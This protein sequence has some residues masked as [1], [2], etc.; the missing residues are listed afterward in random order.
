MSK[1][2]GKIAEWFSVK[3]G[4][5]GTC[6]NQ[7]F[8]RKNA[9]FWKKVI[10]VSTRYETQQHVTTQKEITFVSR[11]FP[12]QKP[13]KDKQVSALF[14]YEACPSRKL[15][16]IRLTYL[17]PNSATVQLPA[18]QPIAAIGVSQVTCL[19]VSHIRA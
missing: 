12:Q 3:I 1:G 10:S 16:C 17:L 15:F 18:Y 4:V 9:R 11:A 6:S 5:S 19:F 7:P 13:L 8:R 14:D 2:C